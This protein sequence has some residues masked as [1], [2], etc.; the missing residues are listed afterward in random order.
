MHRR[1]I[2]VFPYI[3]YNFVYLVDH[4][5]YLFKID[6]YLWHTLYRTHSY[7]IDIMRF[8]F[9]FMAHTVQDWLISHWNN[10]LPLFIYGTHCTRLAHI[11]W[12]YCTT[13]IYLW[14]TLYRTHFNHIYIMCSLYFWHTLYKTHS[15]HI[16]IMCSLYLLV[17][18]HEEILFLEPNIVIL[19]SVSMLTYLKI[20]GSSSP[21]AG[22][23]WCKFIKLVI[24]K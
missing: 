17:T 24:Q 5:V 11:T 8:H 9:L 4:S 23:I 2:C 6:I 19:W 15:Y 14:H 13:F 22:D 21:Y 1:N 20:T 7:H 12:I 18:L 16:D 3:L 10:A